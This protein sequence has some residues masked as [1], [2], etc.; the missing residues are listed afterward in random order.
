LLAGR[1]RVSVLLV[2]ILVLWLLGAL[3]VTDQAA[4]A[5]NRAQRASSGKA[6]AAVPDDPVEKEYQKL[7]ADD[8][9]AQEQAGAWIRENDAF[10]EKGAGFHDA[11]LGLRI[12]QRYKPVQKAYEDFLLRHPDHA[13]ARLAFGSFLNDLGKE[14]EAL[15]QWEKAR[16]LDP[17]N[18]AAWN[19]L[20]NYYGHRG[21]VTNAFNYYAKAIELNPNE[22]TYYQNFATT[23]FLFRRDA[24]DLYQID[25]QKVFDRSLEMYRKA[26][27]L[28]PHNF[29]LAND[30]AQTYYGIRPARAQDA[31]QAWQYALKV[32]GD[33]LQREGVYVHL[34]RNEMG[35][36]QFE[37]AHK[38]LNAVTNSVYNVLKERLLKNLAQKENRAAS[39]NTP[40][41]LPKPQ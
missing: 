31:L 38:Y 7:L 21:P 16:N 9:A 30:L 19:N 10:Q 39:T 20:A 28:D 13:R 24:M 37:E 5:T 4:E 8:D 2:K 15:E 14:E 6:A 22:P 27:Q 35:I 11:A 36:G 23:L 33:E 34:A 1:S 25:E 17:K 3:A 26:L 40:P 32:A 18:P 29:V 41:A 12:E